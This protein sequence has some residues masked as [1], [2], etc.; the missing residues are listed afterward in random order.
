MVGVTQRQAYREGQSHHHMHCIRLT[1][2][3]SDCYSVGSSFSY[4]F[5]FKKLALLSAAANVN[6][7]LCFSCALVGFGGVNILR[8]GLL[9]GISIQVFIVKQINI[10]RCRAEQ[11]ARSIEANRNNGY[12]NN[13]LYCYEYICQVGVVCYEFFH[14]L[15]F[16][17]R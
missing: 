1:G 2:Q 15:C 5:K 3:V 7:M 11:D 8:S 6:S 17:K 16:I 4:L 12:I 14:E 9:S 13:S 10:F